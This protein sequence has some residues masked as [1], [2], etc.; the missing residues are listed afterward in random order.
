MNSGWNQPPFGWHAPVFMS[1]SHPV[2]PARTGPPS[3]PM[4]RLVAALV[5]ALLVVGLPALAGAPA[6]ADDAVATPAPA[7]TGDPGVVPVDPAA[8]SA[9]PALAASAPA[10]A[11]LVLGSRTLR[12]GAVGEDV[13]ALQDLLKVEQTATFD[14]TTRKVLV[15]KVQR[16]AG[17]KATGVVTAKA[18]KKIKKQ[19]RRNRQPRPAQQRSPRVAPY[20]EREPRR[21]ASASPRRT[22]RAPTAGAPAR[23][24]ACRS[25]GAERAAGDTG[26]ATR[27]VG[28]TASR[29]PHRLCGAGRATPR[30]RTCA[31]LRCRS[32]SARSTSRAV[33][34]RRATPGRS[35]ARTTGTRH[36]SQA[37]GPTGID[38][39]V[40]FDV[41]AKKSLPLS[42]TTTNAGKSST[43]MR[44]TA[45]IPSS[46]KSRTSTE[47]M[48]SW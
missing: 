19:G 25:C 28:T 7:A 17:I 38:V 5:G 44:Q 32:R 2:R 14:A 13:T 24:P 40:G 26:P 8:V 18:L 36:G 39:I 1:T 31:A 27:T 3:M 35:G 9:D 48:L 10:P 45:S 33:M 42:S 4:R 16:A 29:R 6:R 12:L 37:G 11:A 30:R 47:R 41:S 46:G 20:P 23:C 21:P 22:S 34:D 43:S 15:K